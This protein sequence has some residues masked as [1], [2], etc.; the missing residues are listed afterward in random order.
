MIY[1]S[2][3][4]AVMRYFAKNSDDSIRE[5]PINAEKQGNFSEKLE[6]TGKSISVNNI[7]DMAGNV[8]EYTCEKING[9]VASMGG[10]YK[11]T[12]YNEKYAGRIGDNESTTIKEEY[13][14][15]MCLY[16]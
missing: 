5:Y 9:N 16:L 2:Q 11:Y 1:G 10:Y 7:Y 12:D 13:G 6:A 3:W 14:S 4:Y 15:R 8:E